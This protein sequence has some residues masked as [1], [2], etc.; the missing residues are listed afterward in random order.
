M[1]SESEIKRSCGCDVI[2]N[3]FVNVS[4]ASICTD[5]FWQ[6]LHFSQKSATFCEKTRLATCLV[7]KSLTLPNEFLK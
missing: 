5:V 7:V 2:I 4:S 1:T 6:I 3:C